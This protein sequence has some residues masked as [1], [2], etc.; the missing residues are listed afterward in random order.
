MGYWFMWYFEMRQWNCENR[1]FQT[2]EQMRAISLM[3]LN[4]NHSIW[5]WG[6]LNLIDWNKSKQYQANKN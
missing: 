3:N 4:N 6:T 5:G 2:I 1:L